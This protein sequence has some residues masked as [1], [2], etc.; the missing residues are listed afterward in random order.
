MKVTAIIVQKKDPN[1]VN[2]MVEGK[3]R[4]SFDI[5]QVID[6]GIKV[7][8]E[9]DE[10]RLAELETESNFGKLYARALEYCLMRP[11]SS[12]EI[13]DYLHRKTLSK[14]IRSYRTGEV[15]VRPGVDHSIAER[16]YERLVERGH[17]D[18]EKFANY[19]IE[20]RHVIKGVSMRKLYSELS[21]KGVSREIIE[22][23]LM[24][25]ER[26]D[27]SELLKV[28]AKKRKRYLDDQKLIQYLV[29]QGFRYD[30]VKSAL[31]EG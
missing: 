14:K 26:G 29:R 10:V 30:D 4:F 12:R 22:K 15:K 11:H 19:W 24:S 9:Y 13:K 23:Y 7:G 21:A 17:I 16:V 27:A 20:N 25:T 3:Y 28:I 5:T 31:A 1:R 6:L 2:V 18:D 8:S